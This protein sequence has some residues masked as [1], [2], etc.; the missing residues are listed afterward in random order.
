[1]ICDC[2]HVFPSKREVFS[3]KDAILFWCCL[4][5]VKSN[6]QLAK[7]RKK[8]IPFSDRFSQ[9]WWSLTNVRGITSNVDEKRTVK[10]ELRYQV[11]SIL[12][13][14]PKDPVRWTIVLPKIINLNFVVCLIW[15]LFSLL[16]RYMR[17]GASD[18]WNTWNSFGQKSTCYQY[19]F[20]YFLS[21]F[22]TT[23]GF[24]TFQ[25][26]CPWPSKTLKNEHDI[27][28]EGILPIE[29]EKFEGIYSM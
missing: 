21:Y 9:F 11:N 3:L 28:D 10:F 18:M 17:P 19:A 15:T 7:W 12:V 4:P 20:V 25:H 13:Q 2:F 8:N 24:H 6:F 1:M 22:L 16:S 5:N 27:V 23:S 14:Y 26:F 29:Y